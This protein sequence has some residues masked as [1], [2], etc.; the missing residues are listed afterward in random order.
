MVSLVQRSHCARSKKAR[1][2]LNK[3]GFQTGKPEPEFD[4]SELKKVIPRTIVAGKRCEVSN[5][6]SRSIAGSSWKTTLPMVLAFL[7][8]SISMGLSRRGSM[9][10]KIEVFFRLSLISA[11]VLTQTSRVFS[12]EVSA[13]GTSNVNNCNASNPDFETSLKQLA[14]AVTERTDIP[15]EFLQKYFAG[16]TIEKAGEFLTRSGFATGD[17]PPAFGDKEAG[18]TRKILGEK[19]MQESGPVSLNCRIVL[20]NYGSNVLHVYGFFYFDGP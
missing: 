12:I 4:D 13:P 2:L 6:L 14:D 15:S 17:S 1:E 10:G 11:L 20:R 9:G 7:A 8:S 5:A 3:T 18:I 19:I 16:C